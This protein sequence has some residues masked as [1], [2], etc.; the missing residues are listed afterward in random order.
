MECRQETDSI[1]IID[2]IRYHITG[3]VASFAELEDSQDKLRLIDH[4][5]EDLDLEA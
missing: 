1:P 2:D 3:Q 4:L 5:L